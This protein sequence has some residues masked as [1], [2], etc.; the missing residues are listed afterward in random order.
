[1]STTVTG[2]S[3]TAQRVL[4]TV[5]LLGAGAYSLPASAALLDGEGTE[6]WIVPAQLL[7]MTAVGAALTVALPAMARTGATTGRRAM[8]GAWWG[9]LAAFAGVLLSWLLLN[10]F[11][12]A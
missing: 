3:P 4:G 11:G 7:A 1:M 12:G 10:G 2:M 9:L 6:G 8:T 5:V